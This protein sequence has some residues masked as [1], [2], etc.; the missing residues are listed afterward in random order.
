MIYNTNLRSF[1]LLDLMLPML[2][3]W[4]SRNESCD[5]LDEP[6]VAFWVDDWG[7]V[8]WLLPVLPPMFDFLALVFISL[9]PRPRLLDY[10]KQ[11]I[12]SP[13]F[14]LNIQY[15]L[16]PLSQ[17]FQSLKIDLWLVFFSECSDTVCSF[18]LFS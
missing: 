3:E 1:K 5:P 7:G 12:I 4:E 10:T 17:W 6:F 9:P 18:M 2:V 15:K 13:N 16:F 8:A 14:V 11:N